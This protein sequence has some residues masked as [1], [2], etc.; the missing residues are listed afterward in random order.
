MKNVVEIMGDASCKLSYCLHLLG[1]QELFTQ[2][3]FL[4]FRLASHDDSGQGIGNRA[5]GIPPLFDFYRILLSDRCSAHPVSCL[6]TE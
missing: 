5:P 3:F 2:F 4:F 6:R 1:L